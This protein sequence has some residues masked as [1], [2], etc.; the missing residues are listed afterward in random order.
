MKNLHY[1]TQ[2]LPESVYQHQMLHLT[3]HTGGDYHHGHH[4][5]HHG[6]GGPLVSHHQSHIK[7]RNALRRSQTSVCDLLQSTGG[8]GPLAHHRA[9]LTAGLYEQFLP[10]PNFNAIGLPVSGAPGGHRVGRAHSFY[11]HHY[12]LGSQHEVQQAHHYNSMYP[13]CDQS[14]GASWYRGSVPNLPASYPAHS[15]VQAPAQSPPQPPGQSVTTPLFVDCSVEYDLGE[16]PVIPADS[17][18]LLSIHPDYKARSVPASPYTRPK[19]VTQTESHKSLPDIGDIKTANNNLLARP[20]CGRMRHSPRAAARFAMNAKLEA[21][22]KLSAESR[23][24]GIG[25]MGSL[26]GGWASSMYPGCDV[27]TS[28]SSSFTSGAY[29]GQARQTEYCG[30]VLP[31]ASSKRWALSGITNNNETSSTNNLSSAANHYQNLRIYYQLAF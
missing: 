25:M 29:T 31:T 5:G 18:P 19:P 21:S 10:P 24:S 14:G 28:S 7:K 30:K 13:I 6:L 26:S 12:R 15:P 2:S 8:L 20:S 1:R 9:P 27:M 23:D 17:E 4:H 22:R 3:Q 16:Q 11:S